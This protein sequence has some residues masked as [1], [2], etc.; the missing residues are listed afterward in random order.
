MNCS[1]MISTTF[2]MEVEPL[3]E[4][5]PDRPFPEPLLQQAA[6]AAVIRNVS[7]RTFMRFIVMSLIYRIFL[8]FKFQLQL[9]PI[10]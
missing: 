4:T 1:P 3:V 5:E 6:R 8:S 2:S 7:S 9:T 10:V